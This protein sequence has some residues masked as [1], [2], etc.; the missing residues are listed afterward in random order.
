MRFHLVK[1]SM[2]LR[3]TLFGWLFLVGFIIV[4]VLITGMYL[5]NF[6]AQDDPVNSPIVIVEGWMDDDELKQIVIA[7]TV[8][9]G[10]TVYP[11]M[12]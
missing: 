8:A 10:R 7:R 9:G 2:A 3:L 1:R 4:L 6:M 5:G 12:P 11:V